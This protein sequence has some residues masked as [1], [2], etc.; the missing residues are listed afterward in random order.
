MIFRLFNLHIVLTMVQ[1][2]PPHSLTFF[3]SCSVGYSIVHISSKRD[4]LSRICSGNGVL[5]VSIKSLG[6]AG[7]HRP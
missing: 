1:T 2:V 5:Y 3:L 7:A 6:K 4:K